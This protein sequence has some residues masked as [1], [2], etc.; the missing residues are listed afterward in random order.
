MTDAGRRQAPLVYGVLQLGRGQGDSISLKKMPQNPKEDRNFLEI[1][2]L[3]GAPSSVSDLQCVFYPLSRGGH[4]GGSPRL[5][6][7]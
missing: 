7:Y 6:G 3:R 4:R 2:A 5:F 1:F